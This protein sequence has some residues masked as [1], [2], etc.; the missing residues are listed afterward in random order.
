ML[1][2]RNERTLTRDFKNAHSFPMPRSIANGFGLVTSGVGLA[3]ANAYSP[4][5]MYLYRRNPGFEINPLIGTGQ[6][7]KDRVFKIPMVSGLNPY[8]PVPTHYFLVGLNL[9]LVWLRAK[10]KTSGLP[11]KHRVFSTFLF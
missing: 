1:A 2:Q 6:F 10:T 5:S 9:P 7:R 3:I 8:L 4:Y 11:T